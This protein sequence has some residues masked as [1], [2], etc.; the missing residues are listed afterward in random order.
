M[1]MITLPVY[2]LWV[3][4]L[5]GT[6]CRTT[7][8]AHPRHTNCQ[9]GELKWNVQFVT[10]WYE[11][12]LGAGVS[13]CEP[14]TNFVLGDF[15]TTECRISANHRCDAGVLAADAGVDLALWSRDVQDNSC[16]ELLSFLF[17]V[18]LASILFSLRKPQWDLARPIVRGWGDWDSEYVTFLPSKKTAL[19]KRQ[20]SS[21]TKKPC[22][23]SCGDTKDSESGRLD[24]TPGDADSTPGSWRTWY[25]PA[26]H[27]VFNLL[28]CVSC[29][30]I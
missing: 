29:G 26:A 1:L 24:R 18:L 23:W 28:V 12:Q 2:V 11:F 8:K 4:C 25:G 27:P 6:Q 21:H 15:G 10:I 9:V 20:D 17:I 7:V 5:C 16:F 19:W 22:L 3:L 30:P 13:F 14:Q